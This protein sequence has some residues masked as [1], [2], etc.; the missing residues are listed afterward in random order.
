MYKEVK[1]SSTSLRKSNELYE[2]MRQS[3]HGGGNG[4]DNSSEMN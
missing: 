3:D 4:G 2:Y 1:P